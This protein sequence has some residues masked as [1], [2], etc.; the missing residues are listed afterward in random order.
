MYSRRTVFPRSMPF[1]H[2]NPL[3]PPPPLH[4]PTSPQLSTLIPTRY[5]RRGTYHHRQ[6]QRPISRLSSSRLKSSDL[7]LDDPLDALESFGQI[8]HAGPVAEAD[9][10]VAGTVEEVAA[11]GR[12]EVYP[13]LEDVGRGS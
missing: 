8:V 9:E 11:F 5:Y 3:I 1:I 10:V 12:V 7:L 4:A 6:R 2:S 13:E